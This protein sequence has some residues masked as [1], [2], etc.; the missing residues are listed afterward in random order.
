MTHPTDAL[1]LVPA[2]PTEAMIEA[3]ANAP[4][5]EAR[6]ATTNIYDRRI[7]TVADMV[8]AAIAA[9]PASPLPEEGLPPI[10]F[11]GPH[12]IGVHRQW[13]ARKLLDSKLN[14]EEAYSIV[15]RSPAIKLPAAPTGEPK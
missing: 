7:Q 14:D 4:F 3:A 5:S 1:R 6:K 13:L 12:G 2:E 8:R 11:D 15:R 9:A 10:S